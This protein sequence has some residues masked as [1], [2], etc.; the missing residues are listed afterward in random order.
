MFAQYKDGG[1]DDDDDDDDDFIYFEVAGSQV[2]NDKSLQIPPLTG[3][4]QIFGC[5]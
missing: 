3:N 4:L 5:L 1:D 2:S